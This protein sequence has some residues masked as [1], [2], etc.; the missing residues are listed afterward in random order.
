MCRNPKLW[1]GL[2]VVAMIVA[3][4]APNVG[5]VL[6]ILLVAACPLMMLVMMGGMAGMARGKR[7]DDTTS[8]AGDADEVARLRA[9][10]DELRANR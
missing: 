10:I 3:I 2:G 6:P 5:A 8:A 4:A 7:T 1:I 9:E